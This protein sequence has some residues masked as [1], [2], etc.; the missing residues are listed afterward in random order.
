MSERLFPCARCGT[1]PRY[2]NPY[3]CNFGRGYMCRCGNWAHGECRQIALNRWN[4]R[5]VQ[6]CESRP[7]SAPSASTE[8]EEKSK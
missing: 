3:G 2:I 6:M 4:A 1:L 8:N 7:T 5:Q